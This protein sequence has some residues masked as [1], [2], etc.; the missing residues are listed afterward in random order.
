MKGWVWALE[1]PE[2][3]SSNLRVLGTP[4][5]SRTNLWA[6]H[7]P[8]S[9]QPPESPGESWSAGGWELSS[10]PFALVVSD[11]TLEKSQMTC[12]HFYVECSLVHQHFP[13]I[14]TALSFPGPSQ[15]CRIEDTWEQSLHCVQNFLLPWWLRLC[16]GS[17][18]TSSD[19]FLPGHFLPF[20]TTF[21]SPVKTQVSGS[22][23]SLLGEADAPAAQQWASLSSLPTRLFCLPSTRNPG[24][25]KP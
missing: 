9:G 5:Y 20:P 13:F 6:Q 21:L 23:S 11:L 3:C 12:W 25:L 7:W 14:S 16:S 19:P 4:T 8:P 24:K 17:S 18:S 15:R 1:L 10:C 22:L 2:K